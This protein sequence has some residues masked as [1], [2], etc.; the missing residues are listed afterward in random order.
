[1]LVD[2]AV[3]P[4]G[5]DRYL[6]LVRPTWS[7]TDVRARLVQA[8]RTTPGTVTLTLR[9]NGNWPGFRAGQH[10]QLS[11]EIDGVRHTR[12]YSLAQS[13]HRNDGLIELTVKAHPDG[14]V[15]RFLVDH[16]RPGMVVGLTPPQGDF[17]LP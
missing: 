13:A 3:A 10:T 9:P 12:C 4:H 11:V 2:A 15:S 8:E 17:V 7:S 16:A 14:R 6:E 1:E 5:V